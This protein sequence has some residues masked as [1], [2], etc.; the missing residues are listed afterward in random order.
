MQS[1]KAL[2]LAENVL[3][4][5]HIMKNSPDMPL[6]TS[7]GLFFRGVFEESSKEA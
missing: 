1:L 4:R 5:F 3:Y 2:I 6:P 7:G